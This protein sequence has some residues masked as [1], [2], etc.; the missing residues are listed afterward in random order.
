[1]KTELFLTT[2]SCAGLILAGC[3]TERPPGNAQPRAN[4]FRPAPI[5]GVSGLSAATREKILAMDP[6]RVTEED[7]RELLSNAPAPH[8]ISIHGGLL[9]IKV[10]MISFAEFL[11]AMGYPEASLRNPKTGSFAYGYYDGSDRIAGSLAWH[12]EQ[13]GLRPILVGHS[14]GGIQVVRVLHKLAG[15]PEKRLAVWNPL[16]D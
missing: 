13:D 5:G 1:M 15:D 6:E 9:P 14:L 2:L 8:I 16:T 4:E 7:V 12:Y 11:I 3:A 10:R